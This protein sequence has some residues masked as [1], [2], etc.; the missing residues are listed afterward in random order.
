MKQT[1]PDLEAVCLDDG[2]TD[3]SGEILDRYAASDSRIRVIHKGNEGYGRTMN[4]GLSQAQGKYVGIV[5]PDDVIFSQMYESYVHDMEAENL[6]VVRSDFFMT[7]HHD[8]GTAL[9]EYSSLSERQELYDRV[10]CPKMNREAFFFEKFTWNGLYR[11]SFLEEHGIRYHETPGASYQDNGFWFQTMYHAERMMFR[12]KAFYCYTRD[13]EDASSWNKGKVHAFRD[14]YD[15]IRD[16]LKD[17]NEGDLFFYRLV[18]HF[19]VRGYLA[20]L[21]R[22]APEYKSSFAK[23]ICEECSRY[24]IENEA[25]Y[26][27][28]SEGERK[29]LDEIR[30]EPVG[31]IQKEIDRE[32]TLLDSVRGWDH[33]VIYGA[34]NRG[35][36]VL[37]MLRSG[38][39]KEHRIDV[40]VTRFQEDNHYCLNIRTHEISEFLQEKDT[41]LILLA[42]KPGTRNY[43]EMRRNLNE[44]GFQNVGECNV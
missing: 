13:N 25:E 34:G 38:L 17:Q 24:E 9:N 10:L 33:I 11:R 40:A 36:A 8:D 42:V 1:F 39:E 2:S 32:R 6:D 5:E 41:V 31:Y 27:W 12:N 14:E 4:L 44:Y 15:F 28:L 26:K 22:I 43:E 19:R 30:R 20:T 29:T 18:F 3:R 23:E 37:G 21:G 35:K 16:Y 7:W